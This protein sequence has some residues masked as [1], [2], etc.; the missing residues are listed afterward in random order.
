MRPLEVSCIEDKKTELQNVFWA[1]GENQLSSKA[2][3]HIS[4]GRN[5]LKS[6]FDV[7]AG[8]E[9]FSLQFY[10]LDHNKSSF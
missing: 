2:Y 6:T 10:V 1:E 9:Y 4:S 8:V 3:L 7:S 5:A